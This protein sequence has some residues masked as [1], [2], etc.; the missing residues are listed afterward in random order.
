MADT[1]TLEVT[2]YRP[3]REGEPTVQEYEVPLRRDWAVLD[4]LNHIKDHLDGTLSYRWSCRMGICGSCGMTVNGDAEADLRDLPRRLRARTDPRRA[5]RQLPRDPR[6]RRRHRRLHAQAPAG[7]ARGSCATRSMPVDE[8]EYLQTPEQLE[9][10]SQFS[11]C[12]NCML[13]YSACPVYG[14][15]PRVHRSGGDR[16]GPALQPRLARRGRRRPARPAHPPRGH[17]GLHLRRRVHA[18]LPEGRGP[19]RRDPAVQAHRRPE[20]REVV[21][22]PTGAAMTQPTK[23]VPRAYRPGE[24][25]VVAADVAAT[26]SSSCAR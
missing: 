9:D 4:G 17:L 11:M 18:R 7:Q 13:C 20:V 24:P 10:Y 2:R 22:A 6:P 26:S 12:I 23:D 8:G 14:L 21:R 25:A 5:A 3:D 1:I 16:A 15:D 19:G